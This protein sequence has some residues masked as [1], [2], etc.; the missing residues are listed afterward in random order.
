M[1]TESKVIVEAARAASLNVL[2]AIKADYEYDEYDS[3]EVFPAL[4]ATV[5]GAI[6]E[7]NSPRFEKLVLNA[8]DEYLKSDEYK[9]M[10]AEEKRL[11][12]IAAVFAD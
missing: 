9:A 1:D 8:R 4:D 2:N 12:A 11:E 5:N 6:D 3:E 7:V 10:K